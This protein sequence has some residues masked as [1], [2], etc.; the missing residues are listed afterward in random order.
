MLPA[1]DLVGQLLYF[2]VSERKTVQDIVCICLI[3]VGLVQ[4]LTVVH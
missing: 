1:V 2:C 3:S 4:R